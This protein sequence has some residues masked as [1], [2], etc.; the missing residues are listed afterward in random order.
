M[1]KTQLTLHERN[2]EKDG[3]KT[4][5]RDE[6]GNALK[7]RYDCCSTHTARRSCI[8]NLY[9]SGLFTTRQMMSISGHST[10]KIFFEYVKL[11]SDELADEI[12]RIQD[13]AN[14]KVTSNADLF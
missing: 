9:K 8:T 13:E 3:N 5:E 6:E 14:K 10:E 7:P 2:A 12:S 4:Y 1:V 11:S